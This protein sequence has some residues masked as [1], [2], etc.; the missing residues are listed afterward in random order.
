MHKQNSSITHE[1]SLRKQAWAER[2]RKS[3]RSSWPVS[4]IG[5][6]HAQQ[7]GTPLRTSLPSSR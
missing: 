2:E 3:S 6:H 7:I 4:S 5:C 1:F